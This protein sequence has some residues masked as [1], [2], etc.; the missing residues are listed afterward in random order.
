MEKMSAR[1]QSFNQK[2]ET[3]LHRLLKAGKLIKLRDLFVQL[4]RD[5]DHGK[6]TKMLNSFDEDG[7]TV[8][9]LYYSLGFHLKEDSDSRAI[10]FYFDMLNAKPSLAVKLEKGEIDAHDLDQGLLWA[11]AENKTRDVILY[12]IAGANPSSMDYRAAPLHYAAFYHNKIMVDYLVAYGASINQRDHEGQTPMD[13]ALRHYERQVIFNTDL[14]KIK[15]LLGE[16]AMT[17]YALSLQTRDFLRVHLSDYM[18]Q[19]QFGEPL[20]DLIEITEKGA[21]SFQTK[22]LL[23]PLVNKP[24]GVSQ[25]TLLM[26][27]IET[28]HL[29]DIEV[30]RVLNEVGLDVNIRTGEAH[31]MAYQAMLK[32]EYRLK[33]RRAFFH[34]LLMAGLDLDAVNDA[35]MSVRHDLTQTALGKK[36]PYA[37]WLLHYE[38]GAQYHKAEILEDHLAIINAKSPEVFLADGQRLLYRAAELKLFSYA[39]EQLKAEFDADLFL[40][41]KT[42]HLPLL[43]VLV[44]HNELEAVMREDLWLYKTEVLSKIL[45]HLPKDLRQRYQN[46]CYNMVERVMEASAKG[47]QAEMMKHHVPFVVKKKPK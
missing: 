17:G 7:Q 1:Q 44:M 14:A 5:E 24:L 42:H 26:R 38:A 20:T 28:A 47:R 33:E 27:A 37:A 43:N 45:V 34:A 32:S 39:A 18:G 2:G 3:E 25:K 21:L 36:T 12:L 8:L 11:A 16:R 6:I 15:N 13:A 19:D 30:L 31:Q 10:V 29:D 46:E 9:D 35:G 41:K 40:D 4:Y 22:K 23:R